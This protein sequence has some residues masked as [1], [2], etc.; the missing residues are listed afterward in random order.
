MNHLHRLR[1]QYGDDRVG[2]ETAVRHLRRSRP[3]WRRRL[4]KF[5]GFGSRPSAPSE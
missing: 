3:S 2:P 5:L 1:E 4:A